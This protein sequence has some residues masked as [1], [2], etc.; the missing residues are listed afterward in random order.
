MYKIT[1][2]VNFQQPWQNLVTKKKGLAITAKS[3]GYNQ[4]IQDLKTFCRREFIV[5][6]LLSI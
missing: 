6:G 3:S 4:W 1:P 5:N 2:S